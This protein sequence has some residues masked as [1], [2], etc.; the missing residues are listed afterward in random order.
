MTITRRR[1][2]PLM[3]GIVALLPGPRTARANTYPA[4]PVVLSVGFAAGGGTDLTARLVAQWLSQ[5][6]GQQFVVENRTGMG[7]NLS[8]EAGLKAAPDGYTLLFVGPN[9]TI[10][11][12]LYR[13]LPFD[14]RR[15][16]AP[17]AFVMQFPNVMLVSP[18]LPARS[19]RE[20]L[21]YAKASPG[22]LSFASS[23]HGTS[24]HVCGA[25]F[26]EMTGINLVHVPYRGAAAAY[27]DLI[28]GRVHV[29]FDNITSAM[30]MA[31]SGQVRALAV[32]S[33]TRWDTVPDMPAVAET[34]P[35]FE[36][37]VWYG[38][39]APRGTPSGVV[40][41]LNEAIN[42]ALADAGFAARLAE[43]G[44]RPKAM[45]PPE[46]EAFINDD[47]EKW[48]KVLASAGASGQ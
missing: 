39:V 32:T 17:V 41:T 12:S 25:L 4:R 37:M 47:T 16:A 19:V 9:S 38:I 7:G 36:A 14:F 6:L 20:F 11:A 33:A 35:G 31:R 8:I 28:S 18:N 27:P 30:E 21:E 3:T 40:R 46:F 24:L 44:G 23:G 45:T 15:D 13:D 34:V 2:L 22:Q 5:R 43:L 29:L 48:R 26:N 1:F 10:G 42:A